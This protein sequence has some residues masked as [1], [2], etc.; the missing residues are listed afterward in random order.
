MNPNLSLLANTVDMTPE[1]VAA[2]VIT[3]FVLTFVCLI[4][5]IL[6]VQFLGKLVSKV[7]KKK[8]LNQTGSNPP[9]AASP[10]K[11]NTSPVVSDG[12]EEEVVA[13]ITAAIAAI[14]AQS[15][16]QLVLRSIAK[17]GAPARKPW[18]LAGLQENTKPF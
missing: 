15:G 1:F 10:V 5:L 7:G 17:A 8:P 16:K 18:A 11:N 3:G 14:S 6:F 4:F 12:I 9:A 2:V 13:V